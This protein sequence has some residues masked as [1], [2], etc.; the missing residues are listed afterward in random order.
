MVA[1]QPRRLLCDLIEE[2]GRH[3]GHPDLI[4]EA[5]DGLVAEAP[6]RGPDGSQANHANEP[7]M[8]SA[9]PLT[10]CDRHPSWPAH[11]AAVRSARANATSHLWASPVRCQRRPTIRKDAA[12]AAGSCD[13]VAGRTHESVAASPTPGEPPRRI[14][15]ATMYRSPESGSV[16]RV[17]HTVDAGRATVPRRP[18]ERADGQY[19]RFLAEK[20]KLARRRLGALGADGGVLAG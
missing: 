15:T 4:R 14:C 16:N 2:Y 7:P 3:T 20:D 8:H 12:P 18:P 17:V 1:C 9:A 13:Y 11:I 10:L 6:L 19:R 5:A